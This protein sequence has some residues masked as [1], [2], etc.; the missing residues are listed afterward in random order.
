[1]SPTGIPKESGMHTVEAVNPWDATYY[2]SVSTRVSIATFA[3]KVWS[4]MRVGTM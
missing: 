1:M 4:A 3:G 2:E